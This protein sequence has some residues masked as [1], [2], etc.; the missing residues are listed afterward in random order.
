MKENICRY[1]PFT[2]RP[3]PVRVLNLVFETDLGVIRGSVV[4]TSYRVCYVSGGSADFIAGGVTHRLAAGDVFFLFPAAHYEMLPDDDFRYYYVS[5]IGRRANR[6]TERI[7]ITKTNCVFHGFPA[8]RQMW[9]NGIRLPDSAAEMVGEALLLYTLGC[10]DGRTREAKS[11]P[12][13]DK[14]EQTALAVKKYIDDHFAE[15]SLGLSV[16]EQHFSYSRKYLSA[17]FR[18]KLGVG[19]SA[20][21]VSVR[22]GY[23]R[24]LITRQGYTGVKDIASLCGYDDPLYFSKV[25]KKYVGVA[26][27][28]FIRGNE[29]MRNEGM[30]E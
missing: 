1:V 27:R 30:K 3:D 19:V 22:V 25:F 29:G 11:A 9:E 18:Q 24:L 21:I 2:D 5:Y 14:A 13:L 4:S 6:E 7:G 12:G 16:L 15:P 28:E 23:A 10:I 20:Y 17:L 8:L 26:P